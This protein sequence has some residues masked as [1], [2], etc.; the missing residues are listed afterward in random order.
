V[1]DGGC[2]D[3]ALGADDGDDPAD[4]LASGA[5]NRPQ[6]ERTTSSALTGAIT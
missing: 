3:A 1:R 4:G 6:I 2:A 5:E